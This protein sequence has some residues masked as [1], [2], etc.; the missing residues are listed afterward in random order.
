MLWS[1]APLAHAQEPCAKTSL[2]ELAALSTPAVIVL[3]ERKGTL[4]DLARASKLVSKLLKKGPV[5]V[6]VQAVRQDHQ[7][8]L[9]A[10][11]SGSVLLGALPATLD[12]ENSWGFPFEAY[13]PLLATSDDGAKLVAIGQDY[14]LRPEDATLTVPP[15]YIHV[16]ADAMGDA[17]VPVE[18]EGPL[19]QTV[20]WA[21][22]R[23]AKA[24][25]EGWSGE[26]ALVIVVDRY[27]VE[28]GMGVQWQARTLTDSSVEAAILAN[29]DSRCYPGDKLL[30]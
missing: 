18:L 12:W 5:T 26:G 24:A 8:E 10:Y 7:A 19:V 27:H 14:V 6:A 15:G 3:G 30:P 25:I 21:D 4:P 28:G 17:P 29:A 9:D 23:L 11:T 1:L 2:G 20:A 13:A 16:L 22:H